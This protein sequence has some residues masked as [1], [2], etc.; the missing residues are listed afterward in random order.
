MVRKELEK[1]GTL[2]ATP[3]MT[4]ALEEPGREKYGYCHEAVHRY[5]YHVAARCQNLGGYLKVSICT[6][7]DVR[8]G[9]L[10]PR[11]DIFID[12][13]GDGFVTR[14]R[15]E[16]GSWKWRDAY[17][18]N[19]E[20]GSRYRY[21]DYDIYMYIN[22]EETGTVRRLLG[23]AKDGYKG[24]AEWQEGCRKRRKDAG[25]K[26]LTDR[27]DE[28]MRP[29][30]DPPGGFEE[31]WRHNAFAGNDYLFYGS[32]SAETGFCTS[33]LKEVKLPGRPRHNA[34]AR[35]T[36]CHRPVTLISRGR[37]T[38]DMWTNG[39][40]V[41]C[42][43]RYKEGLVFRYFLVRRVDR[44]DIRTV[45]R[46]KFLIRE[47]RRTLLLE[48]GCRVFEYGDYKLRGRRWY[49]RN[50]SP[51]D[52][53]WEKLYPRNLTR[54]LMGMHTSFL[55]ARE[56]GYSTGRLL[57]FLV[58]EKKYP[59]I[60]MAYKAGLYTLA[61]DMA[62]NSWLLQGLLFPGKGELA[63]ILG[64]DRA[65]MKRLRQMNGGIRAL[66]WLQKEKQ[67]D[68]IFRDADIMTLSAAELEPETLKRAKVP[69]YLSLEKICNYLNRQA[70]LRPGRWKD[71]RTIW[72]DWNDY[73]NMMEKMKMDTGNEQLLKPKDLL[74]AHNEL[75]AKISMKDSGEEIAGKE[76]KYKAAQ[77][78]M[79][80]GALKKYEYTD[81]KY[82]VVAPSGIADIYGEGLALRHC[83]HTCEIYFQRIEI[84]ETFLLFLRRAESPDRPWYTLEVEPGGNIRQKKSVLNEAYKD[85]DD[86]LPFL[87]EWQQWVKKN[88]SGEDKE[89]AEKSDQARRAGYRKLREEKKI[90]WHGSL[91]GTLLADALE[92]DF[93]EV[94][95]EGGTDGT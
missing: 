52:A 35:C 20:N 2:N 22:P 44:K 46:S 37:K 82:C 74:L 54:L 63:K 66:A 42:V 51:V 88:L 9:I 33:C 73:I 1:L 68:T 36:A 15:Q 11:W 75:V 17:I 40:D 89:L 55:I 4:A 84:G 57:C 76:E 59:A 71:I 81:G 91:R 67:E 65:R 87:R 28:E 86:A 94:P 61:K 45:N 64:I 26:R 5:R 62:D 31:W 92:G 19:L 3:A 69:G 13:K 23:T 77:E 48:D 90:I 50:D 27:W 70:G 32:A 8:K 83:I 34:A 53:S 78:R 16:D 25:I 24:I 58:R 18:Y 43:Q 29:I 95:Q 80:S 47:V 7:E 30:K 12:H 85:L 14:E 56:H 60:E 10:Q 38:T 41:G 39:V 72:R 6:R 21:R 93:M 49:E 79:A